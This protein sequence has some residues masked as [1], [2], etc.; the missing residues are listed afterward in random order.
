MNR[1]SLSLTLALSATLACGHRADPMRIVASGHVEATDVR[2]S[3]KLAGRLQTL[4]A[5]EGDVVRAGQELASI[6]TTDID[7]ALGQARAEREQAAAELRLRRAGSR[8]EDIAEMEDQLKGV[9]ADLA[10]AERDLDRMQALLDRGSGTTKARD[11]ARTRRDVAAARLAAMKQSLARLRAGSRAEEIDAS[12]ARV[13]ATEARIAQLDQQLRDAHVTSPLDGVVTEKIA[14]AGELLQAGSPLLRGDRP[15]IALAHRLRDRAR[16][17]THPAR[18][19]GGGRSPTTARR[20]RGRSPSSPPR[21]S[22]RRRTC[23]PGTSGSSSS[24]R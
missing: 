23:R 22:S 13:A 19:G 9:E 6:E 8:K 21:P 17:R 7:L 11:D 12:R 5:K 20:A 2:V 14:E 4:P 24:T 1:T 16:P 10:A 3:T 15:A 18:P